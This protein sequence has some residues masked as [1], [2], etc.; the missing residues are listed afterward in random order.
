[1][2]EPQRVKG[3][4]LAAKSF[5]VVIIL[6]PLCEFIAPR[7][8]LAIQNLR[9]FHLWVLRDDLKEIPG[10]IYLLNAML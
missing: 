6:G 7:G 4:H 5:W 3:A 9:L 2:R 8:S 1:M 10:L